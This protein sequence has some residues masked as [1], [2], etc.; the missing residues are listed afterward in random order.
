METITLKKERSLELT[1][2]LFQNASMGRHTLK[3]VV[4]IISPSELKDELLSQIRGYD[5]FGET[6]RQKLIELGEEPEGVSSF[7]KKCANMMISMRINEVSG[8]DEVAKMVIKGIN[9]GIIAATEKLNDYKDVD[10]NVIEA[11]KS[12]VRMIESNL[13]KLKRFL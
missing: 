3:H 10:E 6:C 1:E 9:K 2:F 13:D 8:M 12:Y 7:M 4:D 11:G 5:E